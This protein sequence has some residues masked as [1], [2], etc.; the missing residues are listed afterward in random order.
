MPSVVFCA[1]WLLLSVHSFSFA[2]LCILCHQLTIIMHSV[3]VEL[4]TTMEA[5][6]IAVAGSDGKNELEGRHMTV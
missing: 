3:V 1:S 2:S 5:S 4:K 6:D